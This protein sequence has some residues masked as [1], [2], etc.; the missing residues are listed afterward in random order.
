[1]TSSLV[2]TNLHILKT[3]ISLEI[4]EIIL[5]KNSKLQI[6]GPFLSVGLTLTWFIW[7]RNLALHITLIQNG[8]E[9]GT[10]GDEYNKFW[11]EGSPKLLKTKLTE[12]SGTPL[13]PGGHIFP[14]S[15]G[16]PS[17]VP[18]WIGHF[19]RTTLSGRHFSRLTYKFYGVWWLRVATWR[20]FS[21]FMV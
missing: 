6:V 11:R 21:G 15:P 9:L 12:Q 3:W 8:T 7:D 10:P 17:S 14:S 5:F 2:L 19:V 13:P 1:M 16:V 20:C 18:F 4:R